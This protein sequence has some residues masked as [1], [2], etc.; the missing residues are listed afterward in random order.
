MHR[1]GQEHRLV[2]LEPDAAVASRRRCPRGI[3][4]ADDGS[5]FVQP[6]AAGRRLATTFVPVAGNSPVT[7]TGTWTVGAGMTP[8]SGSTAVAAGSAVTESAMGPIVS[9]CGVTVMSAVGRNT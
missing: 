9:I 6:D 7:S 4:Y 1:D 3:V 2:E 5:Q 8:A